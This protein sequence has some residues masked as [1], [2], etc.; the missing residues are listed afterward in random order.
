MRLP[1]VISIWLAIS[2]LG[3]Q[4][5]PAFDPNVSHCGDPQDAGRVVAIRGFQTKLQQ[6]GE[7]PA[8]HEIWSR[9]LTERTYQI[10]INP[11]PPD[12]RGWWG[13]VRVQGDGTAVVEDI[14]AVSKK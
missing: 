11:F 3:C 1:T 2:C 10:G 7:L 9:D 5:E 13:R 12:G 6:Q 14:H 8:Q 4:H